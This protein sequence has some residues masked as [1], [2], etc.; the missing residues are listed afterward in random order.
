MSIYD[1]KKREVI[2]EYDVPN[3]AYPLAVNGDL[4]VLRRRLRKGKNWIYIFDNFEMKVSYE[5]SSD[6]E[7]QLEISSDQ[8][9]FVEIWG[10]G[11]LKD[12]R[13]TTIISMKYWYLFML[14][15]TE[16]TEKLTQGIIQ[17]TIQMLMCA[18]EKTTEEEDV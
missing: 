12:I 11:F 7:T 1:I 15:K 13:I 14:E 2:V 5:F 9:Y 18:G 10:W 8:T 17:E 16:F 3:Y 4:L 6:E